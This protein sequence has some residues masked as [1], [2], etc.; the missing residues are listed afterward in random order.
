MKK[1]IYFFNEGNSEMKDLLGGKGANLAQMTSLN[2]PVPKGFTITTEACNEYYRENEKINEGILKEIS[3]SIKLLENITDKKFGD[4]NNPLIVSVRSGAKFSM[5]GMM[6]TIL[7]LGLND[8]VVESLAMKIENNRFIY[9]SYRRFIQMFSDVVKG[10]EKRKFEDVLDKLKEEKGYMDDT[11][12]SIQELKYVIRKF[13]DI[14]MKEVSEEFPKEASKQLVM[15]IEA[16]FKSWNNERALIYRRLNGISNDLGTAVNIQEMVFGNLGNTSGTGVVFS[17]NPA[18]GENELYG[19]YLMN[20]QGEDVVAGIRTPNY[21]LELKNQNEEIFIKLVSIVKVL[22]KH[23]KDMQDIEFT[24]ENNKLYLLQTRNGK[25]TIQADIKIAMDLYREGFISKEEALLKI[26]PEDLKKLLHPMFDPIILK[27]SG[28]IAT[29]LPASPG[30][31]YGKIVFNSE[32]SKRRKNNNEKTILVRNETSPEDIEGMLTSQGVLTAK[33]GMTSHAAVVARGIGIPCITGCLE[34]EINEDERKIKIGDRTFGENDYISIDGATGNIYAGR[35]STIE[36]KISDEFKEFMELADEVKGLKVKTNADNSEDVKIAIKFGAEGIGLCRTEHMFFGKDR[37][38]KIR[39]MILS[40]TKKQREKAL[41]E[42]MPI[43]RKD[44][45]EIYEVLKGKDVTIRLLDPPLHEFLPRDKKEILE[46]AIESETEI[47]EIYRVIESLHEFNPMMGLRGCRLGIIYPEIV[48]M[49]TKAIIEAAININKEFGYEI[50]P[51]IMVPLISDVSELQYIKNIIREAIEEIKKVLRVDIKYKVG[52]MIEVPRAALT[53]DKIATEAE[54]FCFGTN[55]LTQMALGF[56][57]D[58]SEKFLEKYYDKGIY[59]DNPFLSI[60]EDGVGELMKI[61]KE[62][63]RKAKKDLEIGICGEHGGDPISIQ[64]CDKIGLDYVSCSPY[65]I[66]VAR[67]SA[68]QAKIKN[69]SKN[70][71]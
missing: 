52:T 45:E 38:R 28:S 43:Q 42:L 27:E 70:R 23:F 67:L 36:P 65:R 49:Q 37:I 29:G 57:R 19:E 35:I 4:L 26:N 71:I 3:D 59:K 11:E 25:R 17:R 1:F 64:F 44:F 16:V 48:K 21:I 10:I 58:D 5:P 32:E 41:E 60:D 61:A 2:I 33:G 20:A 22:E 15:A 62:K 54:F 31:A 14:Y 12:L 63:G 13:K 51:K 55:D 34:I 8:E 53:A 7:N 24:I 50:I 68:A 9:D 46:L 39:R 40:T 56:S 47:A 18:N 66:P 6:D 30:A 69:N